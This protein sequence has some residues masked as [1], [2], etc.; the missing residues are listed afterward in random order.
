MSINLGPRVV[1]EKSSLLSVKW[2]QHSFLDQKGEQIEFFLCFLQAS[3]HGI[4]GIK[5][6][7]QNQREIVQCKTKSAL[8]HIEVWNSLK[9]VFFS[10]EL[11]VSDYRRERK[12]IRLSL[13]WRVKNKPTLRYCELKNQFLPLARYDFHYFCQLW[14][15]RIKTFGNAKIKVFL[16]FNVKPDTGSLTATVKRRRSF[17]RK[18]NSC[19]NEKWKIFRKN[20][21]VS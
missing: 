3:C 5:V 9:K 14:L 10:M 8:M 19:K 2:W 1:G 11:K 6:S 18:Q 13:F 15:T 21:R 16:H 17:Q 12:I 4:K 20:T 7:V